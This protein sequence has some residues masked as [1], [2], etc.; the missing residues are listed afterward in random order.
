MEQPKRVEVKRLISK[1]AY[2]RKIKR[3]PAAIDGQIKR[4]TLRTVKFEGGEVIYLDA[5]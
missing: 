5:V 1:S 3:S 2:A 4:G